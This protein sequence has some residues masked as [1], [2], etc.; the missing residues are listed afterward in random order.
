M[1]LIKVFH[2]KVYGMI[3][4]FAY[5]SH[6]KKMLNFFMKLSKTIHLLPNYDFVN[7][8]K[9]RKRI[10]TKIRIIIFGGISPGKKIFY[11]Y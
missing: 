6:F 4:Y 11:L 1:Y 3:F 10:K 9:K 5:E 8:L 2:I 7:N